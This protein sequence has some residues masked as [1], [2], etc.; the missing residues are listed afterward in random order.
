LRRGAGRGGGGRGAWHGV[1][2]QFEEQSQSSTPI[3]W[4]SNAPRQATVSKAVG[5]RGPLDS[6]CRR[7]FENEKREGRFV[8][9]FPSI[10]FV[11]ANH[12]A[13]GTVYDFK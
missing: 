8:Q 6:A 1:A 9:A 11:N 2:I 3:L 10:Y 12:P 4:R 7:D 5:F 13:G